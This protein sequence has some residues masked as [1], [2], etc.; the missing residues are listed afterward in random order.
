MKLAL[1]VFLVIAM[2]LGASA[3]FAYP[4]GSIVLQENWLGGSITLCWEGT[5]VTGFFSDFGSVTGTRSSNGREVTGTVRTAGAHDNSGS[6]TMVYSPNSGSFIGSLTLDSLPGGF[7]WVWSVIGQPRVFPV[8]QRACWSG[9][10][11][12]SNQTFAAV[13]EDRNADDEIV[14]SQFICYERDGNTV[15]NENVFGSF[16]Y[17]GHDYYIECDTPGGDPL[18]FCDVWRVD[19]QNGNQVRAKTLYNGIGIFSN[20]GAYVRG[21]VWNAGQEDVDEDGEPTGTYNTRN[22]LTVDDDHYYL[23]LKRASRQPNGYQGKKCNSNNNLEDGKS[24]NGPL[25]DYT[26]TTP[27]NREED[28]DTFAFP[29]QSA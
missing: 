2:C 17:Q 11:L 9:Q 12:L 14:S 6:F 19:Y 3:Q 21:Y 24:G 4:S 18:A 27:F 10:S 20:E 8:S 13:Y 7:E 29:F 26:F 16:T 5:A 25:A 22:S 1:A 15:N 28:F 23:I